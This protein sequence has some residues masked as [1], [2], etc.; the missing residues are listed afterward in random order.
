MFSGSLALCLA[1]LAVVGMTSYGGDLTVDVLTVTKRIEQQGAET[2]KFEGTIDMDN[3]IALTEQWLSGDGDDEGVFV[4]SAGKVGIGTNA[5]Q[6][7]LH[8][9]GKIR[10]DHNIVMNDNWVSG[11]G[12]NEGVYVSSVGKVGVQ[13][14]P[15]YDLD[16]KGKILRVAGAGDANTQ[17]LFDRYSTS[18]T[19]FPYV[20]FRKSHTDTLDAKVTTVDNEDIGQV[21]FRGVSSANIFWSAARVIAKQDGTSGTRVPGRL[22]FATSTD[23]STDHVRM[24]IKSD[25]NIGIGT[26][27]PSAMLH[28]AGAGRFQGGITYIAPLGDLSMGT[29]TNAP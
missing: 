9:S 21:I 1:M 15:I 24:T 8:V 7:E 16:V 14:T 13:R 12:H 3:N 26:N 22:E 11:D 29:F 19:R 18:S 28:V 2:N 27:S 10:V 4:D 5:P 6:E 17:L 20:N 25:G 23:S